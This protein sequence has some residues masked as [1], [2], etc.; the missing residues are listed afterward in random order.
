MPDQV[1]HLAQLFLDIVQQ[2][3]GVEFDHALALRLEQFA[4]GTLGVAAGHHN[5]RL[6]RKHILGFTGQ[7]RKLAYY[8]HIPEQPDPA[9]RRD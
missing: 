6:E 8:N 1:A 7:P 4:G 3:R 2:A 9:A 5:V